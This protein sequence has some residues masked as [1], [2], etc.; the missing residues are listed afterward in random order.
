MSDTV[1]NPQG[2]VYGFDQKGMARAV[3]A[4]KKTEAVT[5]YD[6]NPLLGASN[7]INVCQAQLTAR[8]GAG[9]LYYDWTQQYRSNTGWTAGPLSG[10][11]ADRP[12]LDITNAQTDLTNAYVTLVRG[13]YLDGSG[14]NQVCWYI[15]TYDNLPRPRN[16]LTLLT[17][18]NDSGNV[19]FV[20]PTFSGI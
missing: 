9:N 8:G 16:Y 19:A 13:R 11:I 4:I 10:T 3:A 17:T 20:L 7:G 1:V 2:A 14:V 18:I 12:A 6:A 5:S 15:M